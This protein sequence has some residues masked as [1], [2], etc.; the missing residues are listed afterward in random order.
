MATSQS[1]IE[2]MAMPPAASAFLIAVIAAADSRR[3]A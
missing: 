2:A 1:V 3:E